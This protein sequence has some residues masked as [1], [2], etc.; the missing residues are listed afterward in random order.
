MTYSGTGGTIHIQSEVLFC[1]MREIW[2]L[3]ETERSSEIGLAWTLKLQEPI[4]YD[5]IGAHQHQS[6]SSI[7]KQARYK[8]TGQEK[9]PNSLEPQNVSTCY[10]NL[11]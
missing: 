11:N 3:I 7:K 10:T 6:H 8:S 4:F 2:K 1:S 9:T 5:T